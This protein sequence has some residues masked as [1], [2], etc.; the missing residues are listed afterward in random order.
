[1]GHKRHIVVEDGRIP[2]DHFSLAI[3]ENRAAF[4]ILFPADDLLADGAQ[5]AEI[6]LLR[7]TV[8]LGKPFAPERFDTYYVIDGMKYG[9]LLEQ[10]IDKR[11]TTYQR[12]WIP[13]THLC[14]H[15]DPRRMMV[16]VKGGLSF[17]DHRNTA[18]LIQKFGGMWL[19]DLWVRD[20]DAPLTECARSI[21]T[22][23]NGVVIT[24]VDD[25]GEEWDPDIVMQGG[26][27]AWLNIKH[28]LTA[29]RETVEPNGW[30]TFTMRILDGKTGELATDVNWDN[31]LIEPVDGY[32]P[33]R[34]VAV[35]NGVGTFR[36]KALDLQDGET[37]RVK[38]GVRYWVSRCEATVRVQS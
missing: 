6:A 34:R 13:G 33:H 22:P 25:L 1:M 38:V 4:R 28:E 27:S 11:A 35:V 29:D 8:Q 10:I 31:F 37:M 17:F 2:Y 15:G 20:V 32:C 26:Q 9:V 23:R 30:V 5:E 19:F 14:V 18:G 36:M 3:D 7:T 24:N 12:V 16:D 21:T